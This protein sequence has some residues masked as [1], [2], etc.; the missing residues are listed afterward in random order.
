MAKER[1]KK[2]EKI[3][4]LIEKGEFKTIQELFEIVAPTP[5][6]KHLGSNTTRFKHRLQHPE[7]FR[8]REIYMIAAYFGVDEDLLVTLVHNLYKDKKGKK[9]NN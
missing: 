3:K 7:D 5:V 2:T 1:D 6:A 8:L 4:S 9:K